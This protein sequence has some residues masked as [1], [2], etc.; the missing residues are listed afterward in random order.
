MWAPGAG[1]HEAFA[2]HRHAAVEPGRVGIGAD[3]QEQVAQGTGVHVAGGALAKHRTGQSGRLVP[4]EPDHLGAGV[5]LHVRQRGDAV[6]KIARHRGVQAA[7]AHH[8]V[9]L[10]HPRRE[11]DHRLPRRIAAAHQRHFLA[12]A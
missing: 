10:L 4:F 2:I 1:H 3:E 12:F 9:Q 5:K 6:D 11:I 7:P 8:Q